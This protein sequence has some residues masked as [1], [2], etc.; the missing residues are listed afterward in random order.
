MNHWFHIIHAVG[1]IGKH[2]LEEHKKLRVSCG[3][4]KGLFQLTDPNAKPPLVVKC[5]HCGTVNKVSD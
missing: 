2:L 1:H 3:M 5:P 4:C